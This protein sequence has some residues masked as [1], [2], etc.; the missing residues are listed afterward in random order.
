MC[1][2]LVLHIFVMN[3]QTRECFGYSKQNVKEITEQ[4]KNNKKFPG[5]IM[6]SCI[7]Q[8]LSLI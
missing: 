8:G 7:N 5:K 2:W 3:H 1:T 4:K 6:E